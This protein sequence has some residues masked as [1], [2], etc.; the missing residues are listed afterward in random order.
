MKEKDFSLAMFCP[1][2]SYAIRFNKALKLAQFQGL[3]TANTNG[4]QN[5][6]RIKIKI[7]QEI[8]LSVLLPLLSF[9]FKIILPTY[10]NHSKMFSIGQ[11]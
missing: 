10:W 4:W 6:L 5:A 2:K 9:S 3:P 1:G 8:D 7:Q 11:M